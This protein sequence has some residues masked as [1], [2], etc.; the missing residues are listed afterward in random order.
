MSIK[1]VIIMRGI[2][3]SGKSTY[4]EEKFDK[5][6]TK[7]CS[8]DNYFVDKNGVYKFDVTKL[9]DAHLQCMRDYLYGLIL[10]STDTVVVDNTNIRPEE[11]TPYVQVAL[12]M[13]MDVEIIEFRGDPN[14]A[15]NRNSHN[16]P[17]D[18]IME[19]YVNYTETLSRYRHLVKTVTF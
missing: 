9:N 13:G 8:A 1:K 7:I 19:M 17:Y 11:Y 2:P 6:T 14:V 16:V 4:I 15:S 12:A 18:K 10:S 3:G 5:N